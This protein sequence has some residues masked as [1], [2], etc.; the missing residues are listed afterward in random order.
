[1]AKK[2]SKDIKAE[3]NL[4][5]H[6]E[7]CTGHKFKKEGKTLSMPCPFCQSK[8]GFKMSLERLDVFN[9]FSCGRCGTI[10]D[11]EKEL[12]SLSDGQAIEKLAKAYNLAPT[13][14]SQIQQNHLKLTSYIW[15]KSKLLTLAQAKKILTMRGYGKL[16]QDGANVL[17]R[18]DLARINTYKDKRFLVFPQSKAN[19][20]IVGIHKIAQDL[21][22]KRDIGAKVG[23]ALFQTVGGKGICIIVESFFNGFA[24]Y[25][26]GYDVIIMFGKA[27]SHA[28][29]NWL[30]K[31]KERTSSIYFWLDRGA[32]ADQQK[33][34]IKYAV[35]GIWFEEQRPNGFDVND[36]LKQDSENFEKVVD[37]HVAK[38][39]QV[40][41]QLPSIATEARN[42]KPYQS[43]KNL[44][45][46]HFP[47]LK[48][49]VGDILP[50]GLTI[51]GGKAKMGKSAAALNIALAV[52]SGGK[53]FGKIDVA[54]ADV[55]YID[56]ESG[57]RRLKQR[58]QAMLQGQE[59]PENLYYAT[60]WKRLDDGG[61]LHIEDFLKEHPNTALVVIDIFGKVRPAIQKY[62]NMYD[63][64][65]MTITA[66]KELADQYH[67]SIMVLH[68]TR[69]ADGTDVFDEL[70]GSS[71]LT[72]AA[73]SLWIL[74]RGRGQGEGT[75]SI[76]SRDMEEKELAMSFKFPQW[77]IL[78]NAA[79]F[80][81]SQER[82]VILSILKEANRQMTPKE[83][84]EQM[85]GKGIERKY[86]AVAQALSRMARNGE[87]K[88]SGY[89]KYQ[90]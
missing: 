75:L 17:I 25:L 80:K 38:A 2:I 41:P 78:G 57:E 77:E 54:K 76:T 79:E 71:G 28:L 35:K 58:T 33:L 60:K 39:N 24:L 83:I 4:C 50:E 51:F 36:L 81:L 89:G 84:A 82:Q 34:C 27:N 5:H 66:L 32:E 20:E 11:F 56:L 18:P 26:L 74:K 70:S 23:M 46:K 72:G 53:V 68:H 64:D 86:E 67:V 1:M 7:T 22:S 45:Q 44:E 49:T 62:Q 63:Y 13:D 90:V 3:V 69:K 65:Y 14:V 59:F 19:G 52:A 8:S 88:S 73:D 55:L 16:A 37:E 87:I 48:F 12:Y 21:H 10:I 9:C 42:A 15:D 31:A 29:D 40:A 85:N 6:I 43:I 47:P 30:P 61:L